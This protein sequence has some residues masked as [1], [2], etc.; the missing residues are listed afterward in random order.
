MKKFLSIVLTLCIALGLTSTLA[1]KHFTA[2]TYE[3]TGEGFGGEL[4]A[5]VEVSDSEILKV[6]IAEHAESAGI[7]D[8]AIEKIP[9]EIVKLQTVNVDSVSGATFSS[10]AIKEAVKKALIKAGGAE[11]YITRHVEKE[12]KEA[13]ELKTAEYDIIIIGAGGAGMSAAFEAKK[14]GANVVVLEKTDHIGGNTLLA[15][16][17]MNAADPARQK[18]YSMGQSEIDKIEELINLEP[19]NELMKSWQDAVAKDMEE[20]KANGETYLYDSPALHKLQTYV[21]GDYVADPA[22]VEILCGKALESV[23][24]LEEN[25]AVWKD[26]VTTAVGATWMRSHNPT[27]DLGTAGASFVL[28]QS[29]G[30]KKLGGE[31]LF[32]HK[33]DKLEKDENGRVSIVKGSMSDGTPFEYKASKA[34]LIATGGFGANV[35]MRQKYNKHWEDLGENIATTNVPTATGDGILLAEDVGANLVGMEWIQLIP[36]SRDSFTAGINNSIFVNKSG[37]RF[38]REDGRRDELSAAVLKQPGQAF[39]KVVDTHT[40]VDELNGVTYKGVK[41]EDRAKEDFVFYGE[42]LEKLAEDAGFD[43]DTFLAA[44]ND[45]NAAVEKHEDKFGRQLFD[46]KIDAGPF[47]AIQGEIK[48]HHTMGGI[49]I[50]EKTQALDKNGDVIPGLYAAGEVTGGIHGSNRLGGNAI[51]DVITFGRIAGEEMSK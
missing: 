8:G 5:N 21:G 3:G 30:Y 38:V 27:L 36:T 18:K 10:D 4:V 26:G 44:V 41:I 22:L 12:A 46:Q 16:S 49:N 37:E 39:Y 20:Y 48:V 7:S 47:Y 32:D 29:N 34:V 43:K 1:E 40:T 24:Y 6:E 51:T 11:E 13:G 19:K 35:E 17:A 42:T 31:V 23:N 45:Y 9:E 15:G 28:P 25:G 14:A 2:G 33:V 50:N